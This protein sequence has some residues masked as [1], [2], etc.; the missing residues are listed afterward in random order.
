MVPRNMSESENC[1]KIPVTIQAVIESKA[2]TREDAS[3]RF[4]TWNFSV[5]GEALEANSTKLEKVRD[6]IDKMVNNR[7]P[8]TDPREYDE[9]NNSGRQL[10]ITYDTH[11]ISA[12]L[13]YYFLV[14][15]STRFAKI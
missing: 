4:Q 8:E 15:V 9:S 13:T 11:S 2:L 12:V 3:E 6:L 10:P 5:H 1:Q 7:D 14:N